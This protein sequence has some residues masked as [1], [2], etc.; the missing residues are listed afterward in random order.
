MVV[1]RLLIR[2]F[3]KRIE[4]EGVERVPTDRGGLLVAWHP[5]GLIDPA[6]IL[7]RLPGRVVFGAR[8]GLLSIPILG[9]VMR[10]LGTVPIYRA[11]DVSGSVEER[12]EANRTSLD[13]LARKIADGSLSALFPEGISH[14]EPHLKELKTGAARLYYRARQIGRSD[15]ATAP[16]PVIIPVGL[17]YDGKEVFRSRALVEFHE[18]IELPA[19]LDVSPPADEPDEAFR[20]RARRLTAVIERALVDTVHPTE[21]WDLHHLM[22]RVRRL[23]RAERAHRAGT[24]PGRSDLA[25]QRLGFARIWT[26]YRALRETDPGAVAD[27]MDAVRRYDADMSTIGI[28]DHELDGGSRLGTLVMPLMLVGQVIVVYLL[29]PLILVLGLLVNYPTALL[30][31]RLARRF[32]GASKDEASLKILIGAVLFPVTWTLFGVLVSIGVIQLGGIFQPLSGLPLLAGLVAAALSALGGMVAVRY[33]RLT[34]ETLRALRV[35]RTR[36]RRAAEV[37]RLRDLRSSLHDRVIALST[38]LDLPG[39]VASDGRVIPG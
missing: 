11:S 6:L 16:T 38:G 3:F 24:S 7:D 30:C 34:R 27:V 2:I 21:T 5:N 35:R 12:R 25:E 33:R 20:A 23:V 29:L 14:D 1:L 18:P 31:G 8:H 32:S 28:E 10:A 36:K 22:H 4:V 17:H 9:S 37:R 26:G 19:D 13:A 39:A 15:D